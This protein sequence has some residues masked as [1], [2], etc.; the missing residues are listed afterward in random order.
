MLI[1]LRYH[2]TTMVAIFLALAVG[3]LVG[4]SFIAGS[5]V[6]GLQREF[7]KL[8]AD[9]GEQRRIIDDMRGE[10]EKHAEFDRATAPV[11]VNRRLSWRRIAIIQTG[12]Y[13]EA[14]QSAKSILEEAGA[15]VVSVT[16]LSNLD[17]PAA[18]ERV[19]RAVELITGETAEPDPVARLLEILANC[20]ATGSNPGALDVLEKKGLLSSTGEYDR[21]T[22]QVVL[23]GG[24]RHK[25]SRRAEHIDLPLIDK[26]KA[27]GVM[28]VVGSEPL[29]AVTSYI[30]AYHRKAIPTV[31]NVDRPM[32]Q[33]ALV[34]AMA[35][36]DGNFGLKRSADRIVP[37]YI[38]S[39]QWRF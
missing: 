18:R 12:D 29:D 16:T 5:S 33:V 4:S 32:G 3:I 2:L 39:G 24:S 8:R 37:A 17:S 13:S 14:T 22:L 15:K 27:A 30:S 6:Q 34:Y 36:E 25:L 19:V 11:L 9:N 1:D 10:L 38:E 31:D 23:V 26:L 35:G 28:R 7:S 21:Q 20:I